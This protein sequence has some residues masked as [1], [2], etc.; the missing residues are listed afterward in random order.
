NIPPL[1]YDLEP[2]AVSDE[3][4]TPMDKEIEKLVAL[5]SIRIG[6]D[7][8]TGKYENQRAV[9]VAGAR[10]D[11]GTQIVRQ[12]GI[13]CSN[14]K[15]LGHVAREC[16]KAKRVYYDEGL[17][18]NLFSVGQFCD[19]DLDVVFRKSSCHNRDLKGNDLL[20]G[21]RGTNLYLGKIP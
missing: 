12:I 4:A 5:I 21:S 15:E 20:T 14:C 6:Y 8:Q 10:E 11:V 3:E 17:N 2:E 19:A 18:H 9:N 7:R 13:Q 16:K 1:I